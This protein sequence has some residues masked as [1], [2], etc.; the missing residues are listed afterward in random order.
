M[1]RGNK[2]KSS[3]GAGHHYL[4]G[5]RFWSENQFW[6]TDYHTPK[7]KEYFNNSLNAM[8]SGAR[9]LSSLDNTIL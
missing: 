9:V 7:A 2:R 6:N 4:K 3:S 8:L 5:Y 1:S